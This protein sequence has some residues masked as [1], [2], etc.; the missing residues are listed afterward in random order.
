[1]HV[2]KTIEEV[3]TFFRPFLRWIPL[4]ASVLFYLLACMVEATEFRTKPAEV[5]AQGYIQKLLPYVINV[6]TRQ[7]VR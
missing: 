3:R 7:Y 5:K 6:G 2:S 1:M 4:V